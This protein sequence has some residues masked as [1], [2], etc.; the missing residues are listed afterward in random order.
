MTEHPDISRRVHDDYHRFKNDDLVKNIFNSKKNKDGAGM[1]I[2]DWMLTEEM[3]LTDHYKMHA[4]VFRSPN[5][6]TI[7]GESSAPRKST[8]IRVHVPRR[9]DPETPIPTAADIDVTNLDETIQIS[10]ATQRNAFMNDIFNIQEDPGTRIELGSY[11]ESPEVEIDIDLV[12]INANDEEEES[13]GDEFELKRR[14]KGK[15]IEETRDTPP[16]TP[17]R[18]PR[19]HIA[20]LSSDKETL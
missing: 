7:K 5:P 3:K 13:A 9:Q 6:V 2:P 10:I 19:T 15:G 4:V 20:H 17:I 14:E 8:V 18:S 12:I 1:K 11:K 16:T